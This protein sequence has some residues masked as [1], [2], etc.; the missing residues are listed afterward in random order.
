MSGLDD[1]STE[2]SVNPGDQAPPRPGPF[3]AKVVGVLDQEYMGGLQV[4]LMKPGGNDAVDGQTIPVKMLTP[5]YGTTGVGNVGTDPNDYNNTQKS[6]GMW[7]VPP[8]V[9]KEPLI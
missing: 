8:D 5:F 1:Q 4:Q 7:F 9:G 3:L 2:K 6:Y